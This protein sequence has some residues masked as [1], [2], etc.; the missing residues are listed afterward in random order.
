MV[1]PAPIQSDGMGVN[2]I[3]PTDVEGAAQQF[4]GLLG[5][6]EQ[7]PVE[8]P[9]TEP[10]EAPVETQETEASVELSEEPATEAPAEQELTFEQ[11][12]ELAEATGLSPDKILAMKVKVK[13]D[14]QEQLI[15]LNQALTSY[16][17]REHLDRKIQE[18]ADLRK[19]IESEREA[20]QKDFQG[21]LQQADSLIKG[22]EDAFMKDVNAVDWQTLRATDPAEYS[23]RVA[24]FN[25]RQAQI[26]NLKQT[27]ITEAQKL[28]SEL[29][30]KQK[31]QY[32]DFLKKEQEALSLKLPEWSDPEKSRSEKV[33]LR[34]YLLGQGFQDTEISNIG[35]HR[36][37]LLTRKAMLYDEISQ[38][39]AVATK[40]VSPLPKFIKPG[41]K[42]GAAEAKADKTRESMTRLQKSGRT[43]DAADV[44]MQR[45]FK[46]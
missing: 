21:R 16:Q 10:Q 36:A 45:L 38:K 27:A 20:V 6:E 19:Q 25:I 32:Q 14:G 5:A 12:D 40:K 13:V 9:K 15:P 1:E 39:S 17:L 7:P 30:E 2:R 4:L 8:A 46:E 28:Q 31:T 23:A 34:S 24:D 26:Q 3:Q 11:L 18:Q 41:A 29:T 42:Q 22:L 43:E 44:I 33:K 37:I 35:D